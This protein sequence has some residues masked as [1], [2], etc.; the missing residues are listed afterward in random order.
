MSREQQRAARREQRRKDARTLEALKSCAFTALSEAS[1]VKFVQV[2]AHDG[3]SGDPV[4]RFVR[5]YGWTGLLIEPVPYLYAQLRKNYS[6]FDGLQFLNACGSETAGQV[7]FYAMRELEAPPTPYYNQ[8]SSLN[9]DVILRYAARLPDVA[10][11]IEELAVDS[12]PLSAITEQYAIQP[13]VLVIDT[14]GYDFKALATFDFRIHRPQ[15]IYFEWKHL[16]EADRVGAK[17][18]LQPLG[19]QLF[20]DGG[21][22]L[23][24]SEPLAFKAASRLPSAVDPISLI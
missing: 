9:R 19:Y 8:L 16:S 7:T 21:N 23:A 6:G 24:L 14:E 20:G 17:A 2:G 11:Y 3:V 18:L 1:P 4:H 15:A 5:K 22:A 10:D 13:D 12:L